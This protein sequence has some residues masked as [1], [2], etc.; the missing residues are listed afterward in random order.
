MKLDLNEKEIVG[1]LQDAFRETNEVLGRKFAQAI[2]DPR[3]PWPGD[4]Q[5]HRGEAVGSPRNIVDRGELKASYSPSST[6]NTYRHAYTAEH[7]MAVHEGAVYKD[8]STMTARPWV[9]QTLRDTDTDEVFATLARGKLGQ[10][11]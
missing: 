8:G 1:A 9:R 2:D 6:P 11:Q 3:W 7:A 10:I 5:R 4:T